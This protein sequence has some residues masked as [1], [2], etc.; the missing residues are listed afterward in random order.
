LFLVIYI[1]HK[2]SYDNIIKAFNLPEL[3]FFYIPSLVD[4]LIY[5]I[6]D[7]PRNTKLG[8]KLLQ[9]SPR[10]VATEKG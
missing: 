9:Q 7:A 8:L 5:F 1:L 4:D 3:V 10:V 2:I 6:G